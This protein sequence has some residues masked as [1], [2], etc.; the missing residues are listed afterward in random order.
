[1]ITV[2]YYYYTLMRIIYADRTNACP[3]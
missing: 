3:M 1:M 2:V